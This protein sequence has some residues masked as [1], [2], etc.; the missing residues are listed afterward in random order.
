MDDEEIPPPPHLL[1]SAGVDRRGSGSDSL[2]STR[3]EKTSGSIDEQPTTDTTE[4]EE[5]QL[6]RSRT[7]SSSVHTS[8]ASSAH[9]PGLKLMWEQLKKM[10]SRLSYME[11]TK[12][13]GA[14]PSPPELTPAPLTNHDEDDETDDPPRH[15]GDLT[16]QMAAL[17]RRLLAVEQSH[18]TQ[19]QD[20][21]VALDK[22]LAV[23]ERNISRTLSSVDKLG[24][25]LT[26]INRKHLKTNSAVDVLCES[27]KKIRE[28]QILGQTTLES[29]QTLLEKGA[30]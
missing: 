1:V 9:D 17:E 20:P 11:D 10:E 8:E 13:R 29:I 5:E 4:D 2:S 23:M 28:T 14:S 21:L 19:N 6:Q 7:N 12:P 30:S 3:R 18:R 25:S 15:V 16:G 24:K 22:R 26:T 27:V